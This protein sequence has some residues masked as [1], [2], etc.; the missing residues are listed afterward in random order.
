MS[1][2]EDLRGELIPVL[3]GVS[4]R[5]L[6]EGKYFKAIERGDR[7]FLIFPNEIAVPYQKGVRMLRK[8]AENSGMSISDAQLE[9]LLSDWLFEIKHG[10]ESEARRSIDK[11]IAKLL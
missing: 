5:P 6:P 3:D 7:G 1:V 10:D 9:V 4:R 8:S 2:V 11:H